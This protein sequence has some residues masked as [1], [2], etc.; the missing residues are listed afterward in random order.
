[1]LFKLK[2]FLLRC[3]MTIFKWVTAILPFKWPEL[4]EGPGAAAK[5]VTSWSAIIGR[6]RSL[7]VPG[8]GTSAVAPT[9]QG[10]IRPVPRV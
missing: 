1:M 4:F 5:M 6:R 3:Y 2:V 9:D 10:S 8:A 7:A